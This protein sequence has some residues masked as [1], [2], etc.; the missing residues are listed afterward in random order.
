M[1]A[2][3]DVPTVAASAVLGLSAG[4]MLAEAAVLVPYWR[5]LPPAE[6][7]RWYAA[8]AER[9][10]VFFGPL[11]IAAFVLALVALGLRHVRHL[12]GRAALG[13]AALLALGVLAPF[14]AY[15]QR[16]NAS[17][18]AATIADA[19]VPGELARWAAWHWAR[20]AIGTAAFVAA[21]LALGSPRAEGST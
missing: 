5:S 9:L 14:P 3:R 18:A 16:V 2:A 13:L 20:T 12:P 11:E 7:L 15:F 6:F 4:A 8:N 19:A 10:L 1:M 17:F 21:L